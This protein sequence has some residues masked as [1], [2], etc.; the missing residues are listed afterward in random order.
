M[1]RAPRCPPQY[2]AC[3]RS[4]VNPHR[5]LP[6]HLAPSFLYCGVFSMQLKNAEGPNQG[7][8]PPRVAEAPATPR[9]EVTTTRGPTLLRH[10]CPLSC[11]H[12]HSHSHSHS[13]TEGPNRH[14]NNERRQGTADVHP[15]PYHYHNHR[16]HY[17]YNPY[18]P[19]PP[20]TLPLQQ[21]YQQQGISSNQMTSRGP[22]SE[23][24]ECRVP[25]LSLPSLSLP[26]RLSLRPNSPQ[27]PLVSLDYRRRAIKYM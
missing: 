8:L 21:Q 1:T 23:V 6:C 9:C 16:H 10:R 25:P 11:C 19:S 12:S 24:T 20:Q 18:Q 14:S 15:Q 26:T 3:R 22:L 2:L 27:Q 4:S 13:T 17:H 7:S 5:T